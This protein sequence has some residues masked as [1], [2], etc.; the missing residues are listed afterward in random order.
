MA[1]LEKRSSTV[2]CMCCCCCGGL[3]L[4]L[5]YFPSF[6][7]PPLLS[8]QAHP[9]RTGVAKLE[10]GK[11]PNPSTSCHPDSRK[12]TTLASF[13]YRSFRQ[14]KLQGAACHIYYTRHFFIECLLR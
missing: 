3:F 12:Q 6:S 14:E 1:G 2:A 4:F 9:Q 13:S 7:I 10:L 11:P 8:H 5:F